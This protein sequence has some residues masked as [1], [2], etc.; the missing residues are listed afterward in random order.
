MRRALV[1]LPKLLVAGC[2]GGSDTSAAPPFT[3]ASYGHGASRV[4]IYEPRGVTR[5]VAVFVHGAGDERETTPYYHRP[6]LEHLAR[7]G[8]AAVYPRYE[9]SPL[10]P[11]ALR[12]L[13]NGVRLASRK[14]PDDVPV[15]GIGYSRGGRLVFEWAREARRSTGL[16]PQAILSVFPSGQMDAMHDLHPLAG[17]TKV[18]ILSGDADQVVG[19]VGVAQLADQLAAS[20]FPYA[21]VQHE[22]VR[23]HGF[24]VATYLSVLENDAVARRPAGRLARALTGA[25]TPRAAPERRRRPATRRAPARGRA[26]RR[27][28]FR[29]TAGSPARARPLRA[30]AAPRASDRRPSPGSSAR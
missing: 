18:L 17:R 12:H 24:F 19:T 11:G 27:T 3:V 1:V 2:G 10:Q 23:S 22:R 29:P 15:L 14:L 9:V 13:E 7:T 30:R 28:S 16:F 8:V 26:A 21:D 6:W 4:W 20:E 5:A 25:S